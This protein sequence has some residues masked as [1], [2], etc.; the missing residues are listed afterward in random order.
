MCEDW[1]KWND[2]LR[3]VQDTKIPSESSIISTVLILFD[4]FLCILAE[5]VP[6]L[7]HKS[8]LCGVDKRLN[9]WGMKITNWLSVRSVI[10]FSSRS[11]NHIRVGSGV[12]PHGWQEIATPCRAILLA[13]HCTLVTHFTTICQDDRT[14]RYYAV[15][16]RDGSTLSPMPATSRLVFCRPDEEGAQRKSAEQRLK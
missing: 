12:F 10:F 16:C 14:C 5:P 2:H 13:Y 7:V 6:F 8:Q 11:I 4:L 15:P 1:I 9:K 3:R